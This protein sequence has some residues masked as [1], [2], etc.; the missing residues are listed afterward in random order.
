MIV[1]RVSMEPR[2]SIDSID[3]NVDVDLDS[4]VSFNK[5]Y[6]IHSSMVET[7]LSSVDDRVK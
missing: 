3:M 4:E 7:T 2:V 5:E 6:K 1:I